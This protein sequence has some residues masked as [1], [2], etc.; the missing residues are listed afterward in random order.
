M[1]EQNREIERLRRDNERLRSEEDRPA[2]SS[3]L[4][5]RQD[6]RK[7]AQGKIESEQTITSSL[8]AASERPST[9]ERTAARAP[10]FYEQPTISRSETRQVQQ[11]LNDLGFDAGQ[12]DG[13]WGPNTETALRNFQHAKGLQAT[14][15]LDEKTVDELGIDDAAKNN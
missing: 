12:V 5:Q 3:Q 4:Q 14:G 15:R 9:D 10:A 2:A 7:M 13:L 1:D 8:A 11:K 6:N